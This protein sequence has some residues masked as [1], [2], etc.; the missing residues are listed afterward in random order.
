MNA[1]LTLLHVVHD[2]VLAPALSS[3]A[4]GDAAAAQRELQAI[5][6]ANADVVCR[7]DVRTA[8]D[9]AQAI[10]AAAA[11]ADFLFVGSHGRSALQRLR[12]G[13]A[14]IAVLRASSVPVV[15]LPPP[16]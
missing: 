13:S 9:V 11:N 3:D 7:V 5:A 1:T 16:R 2:P 15:C 10:V 12:L 4:P 14:A 6:D 8:E